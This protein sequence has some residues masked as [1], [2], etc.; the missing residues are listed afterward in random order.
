MDVTPVTNAH[1]FLLFRPGNI[2]PALDHARVARVSGLEE[3]INSWGQIDSLVAVDT[4]TC[5]AHQ[6]QPRFQL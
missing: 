2:K 1:L 6:V 3:R 5:V 4:Q